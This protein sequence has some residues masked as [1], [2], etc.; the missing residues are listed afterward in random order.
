MKQP[1]PQTPSQRQTFDQY[2]V[3]Q[4]GFQYPEP[5]KPGEPTGRQRGG[6][7]F[8]GGGEA[9]GESSSSSRKFF[10]V[11]DVAKTPFGRVERGLGLQVQSDIPIYEIQD[12]LGPKRKGSKPLQESYFDIGL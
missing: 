5:G 12:V 11:F 3:P 6:F 4:Q 1:S 7:F 8:G 10:R 2:F 9:S